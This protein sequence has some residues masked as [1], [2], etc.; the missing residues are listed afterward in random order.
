[1]YGEGDSYTS[2]Q[3]GCDPDIGPES[4]SMLEK[5]EEEN[6]QYR[7]EN[8]LFREQIRLLLA[9]RYGPSSEKANDVRAL[10]PYRI[11]QKNLTSIA[12]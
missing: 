10:L 4:T 11:L 5:K 1:M 7:I 12:K 6:H 9:K 2:R 8:N 3:Y